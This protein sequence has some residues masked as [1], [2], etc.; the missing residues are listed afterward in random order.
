MFL[1]EAMRTKNKAQVTEL[2]DYAAKC[3]KNLE[4]SL[5]NLGLLLSPT[6]ENIQACVIGASYA[7]EV[8]KPSL[9]WLLTST[10][11][12]MCQS[13]GYHRASTLASDSPEDAHIKS[14]TFWILYYFDKSMSIR[15][16]RPSTIQDF[17]IDLPLPTLGGGLSDAWTKVWHLQIK[18][19]GVQGRVYEQLF[20]RA[21]L[22]EDVST[23]IRKAKVLAEEV[24]Q[25]RHAH[26][27]VG[28]RWV[29]LVVL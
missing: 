28:N 10:A 16:G 19:G 12:N 1:E 9:C 4:I 14:H 21:A 6:M 24:K 8:S 13:L 23:R 5:A 2:N 22:L 29:S 26:Q 18:T 27:N 3:K 11:V 25:I 20:S 15:L 17:D 7:V